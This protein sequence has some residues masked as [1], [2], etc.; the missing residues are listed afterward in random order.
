M[1]EVKN[2]LK[3]L[4]DTPS[5]V[6]W[7]DVEHRVPGPA[8]GPPARS[9]VAAAVVALLVF[10]AAATFSW[11]A[12]RP[13]EHRRAADDGSSTPSGI[14]GSI[15]VSV[16]TADNVDFDIY[17]MNAEGGALTP[18]LADPAYRDSGAV[19]SPDGSTIAFVR[20]LAPTQNAQGAYEYIGGSEIW[21]QDVATGRLTQLTVSKYEHD[22]PAWSPDGSTIAYRS[23]EGGEPEIWLMDAD[24]SH[25]RVLTETNGYNGEPVWSPDGS[26]IAFDS[27]QDRSTGFGVS[28]W[29]MNADGSNV[30]RLTDSDAGDIV[31]SWSPDGTKIAFQR[32]VN[33]SDYAWDV[34]TM[35]VDGSHQRQLTNWPGMD[36]GARWSPDGTQLLF[37]SD[38]YIDEQKAEHIA[39]E[40]GG[41]A[42]WPT[43]V[44][45]MDADG[46]NVRQMV[47]PDRYVDPSEW[48]PPAK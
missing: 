10:A 21:T 9:R 38:R 27:D 1:K 44:Y 16:S 28:V 33:E 31:T 41:S 25:Q 19:L 36:G 14:A 2:D 11:A 12:L 45:L 3:R 13:A 26:K 20:S 6:S 24:G 7:S 5:L 15:L 43:A 4:D 8:S 40:V 46:T 22:Q 29:V 39:D 23:T 42:S 34:W 35:N 32:S 30:I 17:K 37:S 18:V 48:T 47:P